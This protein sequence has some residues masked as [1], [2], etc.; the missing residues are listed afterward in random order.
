MPSFPESGDL[1][2]QELRNKGLYEEFEPEAKPSYF[3]ERRVQ[4]PNGIW[5]LKNAAEYFAEPLP[6][7]TEEF[8]S[9]K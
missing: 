3:M 1:L 7:N 4:D 5:A 6:W 2:I 8:K 9:G